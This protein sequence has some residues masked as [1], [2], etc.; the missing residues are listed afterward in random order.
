MEILGK[1][2]LPSLAG[3]LRFD[4]AQTQPAL[5]KSCED[6]VNTYVDV[7]DRA[8]K[9]MR[10]A[11][12]LIKQY[13][14]LKKTGHTFNTSFCKAVAAAGVRPA[15][16]PGAGL[17]DPCANESPADTVNAFISY[18]TQVG[19][20]DGARQALADAV[21]DSRS[22]ASAIGLGSLAPASNGCDFH[23]NFGDFVRGQETTTLLNVNFVIGPVPCNLEVSSYMN[24]G[25]QGGLGLNL[26]PQ[27]LVDGSG[28]FAKAGDTRVR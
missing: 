27:A 22:L 7:I 12:E 14:D 28:D 20:I 8:K 23:A 10:D 4:T 16:M 1:D 18:R 13:E 17:A 25:I 11:Q 6:A 24:Y 2:F 3:N 21:L 9:A 5:T 15:G 26:R 19:L